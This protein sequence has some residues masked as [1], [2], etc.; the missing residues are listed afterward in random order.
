[1]AASTPLIAQEASHPHLA[2]GWT[3]ER[4]CLPDAPTQPPA[5][6]TFDGTLLYWGGYGIHGYHQDWD[7]TRIL[8]F[9]DQFPGDHIV[10][11]AFSPDLKQYADAEGDALP[12][13]VQNCRWTNT[14]VDDISIIQVPEVNQNQPKRKWM[15][16]NYLYQ[17]DTYSNE[18]EPP[19]IWLDNTTLAFPEQ[20]TSKD[21]I[22]L[23]DTITGEKTRFPSGIDDIQDSFIAVSPD[24]TRYA[25]D[26]LVDIASGKV[27]LDLAAPLYASIPYEYDWSPQLWSPDASHFLIYSR[28]T[29]TDPYAL[30]LI[31]RNGEEKNPIA[32]VDEASLQYLKARWSPHSNALFLQ[33]I[34]HAS[35]ELP[36]ADY[37]DYSYVTGI[38]FP[39]H[40]Y[41]IDLC[42]SDPEKAVYELQAPYLSPDG[43]QLLLGVQYKNQYWLSIFSLKTGKWYLVQP[44]Y[45]WL[46]GWAAW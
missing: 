33:W 17:D 2:D 20:V 39:A 25:D 43:S 3:Y 15:S 14:R 22:H 9:I 45:G 19:L 42:V 26:Q 5:D 18:G 24:L 13:P 21:E 23:L 6:W 16:W 40:R 37:T 7:T 35:E 28:E 32:V 10:A 46:I 4:T 38:A 1:M 36:E 41:F 27:I 11:S 31:D 34:E 30:T 8:A 44:I 12:C 29:E